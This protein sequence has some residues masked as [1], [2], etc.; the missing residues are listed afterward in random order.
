MNNLELSHEAL[1]QHLISTKGKSCAAN[2]NDFR[3]SQKRGIDLI[4]FAESDFFQ[5]TKCGLQHLP[6]VQIPMQ[7]DVSPAVHSCIIV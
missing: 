4:D 6:Y 7:T 2:L 3:Q 1:E 5:R